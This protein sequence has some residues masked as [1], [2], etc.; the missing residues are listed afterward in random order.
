MIE[1]VQLSK[2]FNQAPAEAQSQVVEEVYETISNSNP[3]ASE[4]GDIK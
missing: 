4:C 2:V 1:L 3:L